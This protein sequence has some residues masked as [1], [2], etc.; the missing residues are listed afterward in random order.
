[1]GEVYFKCKGGYVEVE[2]ISQNRNPSYS[3]L[4]FN[5]TNTLTRPVYVRTINVVPDDADGN[6]QAA[7]TN[8]EIGLS[9]S[10]QIYPT[11]IT[12]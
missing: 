5:S 9:R 3:K 11:S 2:K 12:W 10:I 7:T 8:N 4:P 1:M 6:A